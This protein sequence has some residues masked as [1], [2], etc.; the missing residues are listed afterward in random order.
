[1]GRTL[2]ALL[3][4]FLLYFVIGWVTIGTMEGNTVGWISIFALAGTIVNYL[5]GDMYILP[6]YGNITACLLD[7][8]MGAVVAYTLG[9]LYT[10]FKVGIFTLVILAL[11][12]AI[13]E[14]FFHVYLFRDKFR[15]VD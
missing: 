1:M 5:L 8:F 4:K 7:G 2:T 13:G 12:T 15:K 9:L 10:E 3:S 14:Y 11:L 6:Q